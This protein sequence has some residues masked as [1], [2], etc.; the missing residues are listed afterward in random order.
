M[1]DTGAV[2][3]GTAKDLAAALRDGLAQGAPF[4]FWFGAGASK[5]AGIPTAGGVVD[6][7]LER[8]W[9]EAT[10]FP[11]GSYDL[12]LQRSRPSLSELRKWAREAIPG[13][14]MGLA[15]NSS[16]AQNNDPESWASL[17]PTVLD[18]FPGR[19]LRQELI[20]ALINQAKKLNY[21]HIL[22]A[23][24]MRKGYVS[25]FL[26]TNFDDLLKEALDLSEHLP[27]R[28]VDADSTQELTVDSTILQVAYLHGKGTSYSQRHTGAE[29]SNT[30]PG[31]ESFLEQA[32]K[33]HGLVVI[34]YNGGDETPM[35][36]LL[37]VLKRNGAPGRGLFWVSY[38]SSLDHLSNNTKTALANK[39]VRWI[40]G[41]D[42]DNFMIDLC[43][44]IHVGFPRKEEL[45]YKK[46]PEDLF[47]R[48][49]SLVQQARKRWSLG[50]RS[51]PLS[52]TDDGT[53]T[54]EVRARRHQ[55]SIIELCER[56]TS[57]DPGYAPAWLEL[58][59][60]LVRIGRCDEAIS[61]FRRA[62]EIDTTT[63]A[64]LLE[65]GKALQLKGSHA[66]ALGLFK[67]ASDIDK[68]SAM[69]H[70]FCSKSLIALGRLKE[71]KSEEEQARRLNPRVYP[72][73]IPNRQWS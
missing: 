8:K 9:N 72:R 50:W 38:S 63:I 17:Y 42:A 36:V 71:A 23:L 16:L 49:Q 10:R 1:T 59:K 12:S 3:K 68:S 14:A 60:G 28:E 54:D 53:A 30:I 43:E 4:I 67:R 40:P 37:D 70:Y 26:T 32:F 20:L 47:N 51:D 73:M 11:D 19:A 46:V 41:Y 15:S 52:A 31:F 66:E 65:W 25:T 33:R 29:V 24:L 27:V 58:G 22:L 18:C 69:A 57:I 6:W 5:S 64:P 44:I 35:N 13:I 62:H 7:F 45:L 55:E 48:A 61:R 39:D 34:G 21:A 56:A 2:R